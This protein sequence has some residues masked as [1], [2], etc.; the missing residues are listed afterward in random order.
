M[1]IFSWSAPRGSPRRGCP[2][3]S[4]Q[5]VDSSGLLN[6]K[7][8]IPFSSGFFSV[9]LR[10][11]GKGHIWLP[12]SFLY[13]LFSTSIHSIQRSF[14]YILKNGHFYRFYAKVCKHSIFDFYAFYTKVI[15]VHFMQ[16]SFLYILFST[17]MHFMEMSFLYIL[18]A[19]LL[20]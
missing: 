5:S 6:L 19:T 4:L 1:K 17:S 8:G 7:I 10:P 13:I 14:L 2:F 15:S 16:R 11:F 12:W 9:K 3:R 20:K 18:L